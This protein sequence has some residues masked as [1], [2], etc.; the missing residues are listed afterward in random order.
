MSFC[1]F[2]L[3]I[4]FSVLL[5]FMTGFWLFQT[6]LFFKATRLNICIYSRQIG[7]MYCVPW[8]ISM[9][10][11]FSDLIRFLLDENSQDSCDWIKASLWLIII[12]RVFGNIYKSFG[13]RHRFHFF[14]TSIV[15]SYRT[16]LSVVHTYSLSQ[17]AC[18]NIYD[19]KLFIN[20]LNTENNTIRFCLHCDVHTTWI[21]E[22]LK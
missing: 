1:L 7:Q 5:R 14:S 15:S 6:F 12:V 19:N 22:I 16:L 11:Y 10:M 8:H 9:S 21:S 2:S 20:A 3:V 4:V 13:S 17:D 18:Q